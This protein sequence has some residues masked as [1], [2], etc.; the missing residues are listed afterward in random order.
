RGL[1][2]ALASQVADRLMAH[3][4]LAAHAREEL[5]ISDLQRARPVQAALSSAAAFA[6]G[7]A[8][9][10]V[11]TLLAPAAQLSIWVVSTCLALLAALGALAA[12][13]GGASALKG[14]GRVA[15]WGATAMA[16]TYAVGKL[17]DTVV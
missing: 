2:P 6:V 7:A 5:G 3:D 12:R 15:F 1:E 4:A 9:P 13:V 11:V 17:F 16:L 10:V 8:L 14:A